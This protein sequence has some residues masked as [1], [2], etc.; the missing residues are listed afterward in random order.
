MHD[1]TYG[2]GLE[3]DHPFR[4]I[5]LATK[6][7]QN[8]AERMEMITAATKTAQNVAERMEMITAATKTAQNVANTKITTI[9]NV[10]FPL[11]SR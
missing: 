8:V 10:S 1:Q 7:A 3:R 5:G 2:T 11:L 6:Q 9:I 4:D